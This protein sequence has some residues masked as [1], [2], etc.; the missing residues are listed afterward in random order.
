[1]TEHWHKQYFNGIC[2]YTSNRCDDW[3]CTKC[4]I[5]AEERYDLD[6]AEMEE[7]HKTVQEEMQEIEDMRKEQ[8]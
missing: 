7:Y 6:R 2:P 4:E 8:E 3:N 1:M 5:D